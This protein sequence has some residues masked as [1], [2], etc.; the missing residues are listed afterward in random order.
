MVP[1]I[2][3]SNLIEACDFSKVLSSFIVQYASEG[4]WK[5]YEQCPICIIRLPVYLNIQD[6]IGITV[7]L[8]ISAALSSG[9]ELKDKIL[10]GN[11]SQDFYESPDQ[12]ELS[13]MCMFISP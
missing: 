7:S 13:R 4:Q 12:E 2:V 9:T 8:L 5:D 11:Q 10:H 1:A 3:K 6:E